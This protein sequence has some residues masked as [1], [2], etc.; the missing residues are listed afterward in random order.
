MSYNI[1]VVEKIII[2]MCLL[3]G[4]SNRSISE[5]WQHSPSTISAA[6]YE[7]IEVILKKGMVDFL[8]IPPDPE[9]Q[10]I[11]RLVAI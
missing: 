8:M 10:L 2:L 3:T 1:F 6:L 7:V 5:R 11:L 9:V 4:H